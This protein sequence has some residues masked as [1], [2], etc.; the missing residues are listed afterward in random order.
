MNTP[1]SYLTIQSEGET[2]LEIKRSRFICHAKHVKS[3]KEAN[4]WIQ[5]INRTYHDATHNCYAYV[6]DLNHQKSSDDGEP[7]GTAGRPILETL[8]QYPL[9][10]SI[11][12]I[13][14]YFGGIKLG[15]GGLVR[16]YRQAAQ[17]AIQS[18]GI[19][20]RKLHQQIRLMVDY[21]LFGKIEHAIQSAHY[22]DDPPSFS[23]RVQWSIWVPVDQT[24]EAVKKLNDMTQGN[25]QI[26]FGRIGYKNVT[27]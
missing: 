13:T 19:V 8:L 9:L 6:I 17:L 4:Q 26:E 16:A 5:E 12:I 10:E 27:S 20:E 2:V 15:A 1:E 14:R 11:V 7:A 18:A 21:S 22:V 24:D 25:I 23:D 3:V